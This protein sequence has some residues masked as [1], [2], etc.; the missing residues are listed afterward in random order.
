MC[1]LSPHR[2]I[3]RAILVCILCVYMHTQVRYRQGVVVDFRGHGL[4]WHFDMVQMM[5]ALLTGAVLLGMA[6]TVTDLV[7][8]NLF[9][10]KK[11]TDPKTGKKKWKLEMTATS[12]V[13]RAKRIENVSPDFVMAAQAMFGALA[14]SSFN[15]LD[16]D[17][18]GVVDAE[19]LVAAFSRVGGITY[20][21]ACEM[22]K[23]IMHKGDRDGGQKDGKLTF[24]EFVSVVSMDMMPFDVRGATAAHT[25]QPQHECPRPHAPITAS[26]V[27]TRTRLTV[28]RVCPSLT[29]CVRCRCCSATWTSGTSSA[30]PR[31]SPST[32]TASTSASL[33]RCARPQAT[34]TVT[35]RSLGVG[36]DQRLRLRRPRGA[37]PIGYCRRF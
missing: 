32:P 16:T 15:A 37:K 5:T 29:A 23:L 18:D 22:T 11:V 3:L 8:I 33:S 30:S 36:R 7:A 24:T 17:G 25:A 19:N 28:R 31:S 21:Q 26:C 6:V 20:E 4:Y 2:G 14:V 34:R 1:A 10:P 13:L 12:R 9:R 35:R 27:G